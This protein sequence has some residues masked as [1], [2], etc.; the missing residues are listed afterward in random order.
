MYSSFRQSK[1]RRE[2]HFIEIIAWIFPL[3][4]GVLAE[5]SKT[6]NNRF[7]MFLKMAT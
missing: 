3:V 1:V 6:E 2:F 5:C 7:S 4:P